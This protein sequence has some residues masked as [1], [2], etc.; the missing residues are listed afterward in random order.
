MM[1]QIQYG[2]ELGY[3]SVWLAE[4]HGSLY[5][6]MPR[7]AVAAAA[8]AE[9]TTTMRIGT[10]VTIL[11]FDNPVRTAEDFAM[12]D[13]ISNGRL[14]F[15]VG[16]AYQ[17]L[18]FKNMGLADRQDH[19]RELFQESLDIVLGLWSNEKFSYQGKL[20]Q[21]N[22]VE[23]HPRPIQKPIPIHVAAIS[24]E[25]FSMVAAKDLNIIQ[26]ATL[27][28]LAE[29]K[30]FCVNAKRALMQ[31]GH[32]PESL[33]FPLLWITH[34]AKSFE[35]GKQ[36]SA[37]AMKWY[38]D[39][40]LALVPQGAKAPKSY[41]AFAAAAKAYHDAGGFPVETLNET[42]NL[43]LGTP[44]FAAQRME[45]VRNDMG[46][47]EVILWMQVGGLDDRHVRDSM[48]LFAAEVMPSYKGQAPVVPRA[49]REAP[50]GGA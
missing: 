26:A 46:Q 13:V 44:E 6:T 42:G 49:L 43:I 48:R 30:V 9:R 45:E 16:R 14:D 22:D 36:R 40:L 37:Q 27:M 28:P 31:K 21:L 24:P 1:G 17:P 20:W 35:E 4:H 34:V 10:A 50:V 23:C 7:L 33:D 12:V 29:L 8:I 41:E 11:P 18:E 15:G 47:Q 19:S 2:E 38:F 39:T 3:E 32:R 5:G 25:T